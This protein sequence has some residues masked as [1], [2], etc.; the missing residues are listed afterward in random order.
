MKKRITAIGIIL[1]AGLFGQPVWATEYGCPIGDPAQ[2]LADDYNRRWLSAVE[3]GN[4]EQLGRLYSDNAVLM[5]PTDETIVGRAPIEAYLTTAANGPQLDNYS[6]DIVACEMA[7]DSLQFAGVWGAEQTDYRGRAVA[8]TG[9][10]LR[11][12]NRQ[13]D[14]S[15]AFSYEIWN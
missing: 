6:V 5:P 12:L 3:S 11:I 4:A 8:M 10:V 9:N 2:E 15:W 14:G 1:A 7:G 13:S